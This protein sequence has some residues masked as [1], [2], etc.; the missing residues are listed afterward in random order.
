MGESSSV[1]LGGCMVCIFLRMM[2]Y[3]PTYHHTTNDD[4]VTRQIHIRTHTAQLEADLK[5]ARAGRKALQQEVKRLQG[6]VEEQ[7][8]T[9][10][11]LAGRNAVLEEEVGWGVGCLCWVGFWVD[12]TEI[13]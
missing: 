5:R 2:A 9:I 3:S 6:L 10:A 11:A 1:R 4:D 13:D 8:K 12:W 7:H